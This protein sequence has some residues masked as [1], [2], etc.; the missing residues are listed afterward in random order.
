MFKKLLGWLLIVSIV[1]AQAVFPLAVKPNESLGFSLDSESIGIVNDGSEWVFFDQFTGYNTKADPSKVRD[2]DNPMGQNTVIN[3]TDRISVRDLGLATY[4]ADSTAA[5]STDG[6][7]SLHTFRKRS[8]ENILMRAYSTTTEFYDEYS[9]RWET[10]KSG[11]ATGTTFGFADFNINTDL[12]SYVYYGN[13]VN[14]FTRWTGAHTNLTSALVGGESTVPVVSTLDG[15]V[16]S[17]GSLTICGVTV[18][19]T[20]KTNTSFTGTTNVPAC[21][22]GR[23]VLQ[24][25]LEFGDSHPKGNIYLVA[26]N[27]LFISGVAST[28][29]A[30]FFSQYGDA[31]VYSATGVTA[32][33]AA[34]PG[35]FN[36][37][38]GGGGVT[39]MIQDESAIYIFK[40]SIIYKATLSDTLYTL[41]ALKPFDGKSQTT[42]AVNQNSVFTGGNGV[43][44]I[45]PDNQIMNLARVDS[46][47]YPQTIPI[48]DSIKPTAAQAVF[49]SSSGIF[50]KDRAFISAKKDSDSSVNDVVFVYNFRVG[51]WE[52]PI[53]GWNV[54]DLAIYNDELF[55]A[56]Q[57]STNVYRVTD[58]PLDDIYGVKANWRS[59][60]YTFGSP[61]WQKEVTSVFIEGYITDNTDLSISL[62]LD[63]NGFTQTYTTVFEGSETAFRFDA[64]S[65]NLFGFS[66]FGTERFGSND[67]FSGKR[68]FRVYLNKN[69]R[70]IPFYVA[71]L[72]FASDGE[73]QQWEITRFGFLV[74]RTE[75]PEKRSIFRA[76]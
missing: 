2:G 73:N 50:F 47:D 52:S 46:V 43:F 15:F 29:Q 58:I 10:I 19:Y 23:A 16:S 36:L 39:A 32:S 55:I 56:S 13:G 53:I 3:N 31:N 66:Q 37:G 71:Q 28:S 70:R 27:R 26:N 40:R 33:T 44:F 22:N 69:V 12:V 68:K 8:G 76:F 74:R 42:G 4:P 38:E 63:E 64:P 9:D 49:A 20:G 25:P 67:D 1:L 35:V 6:V 45:T 54:A 14:P 21:D 7:N 48:S 41:S 61:A 24:A 17:T 75:E 57:N 62:L 60:Q 30:V 72:E 5:T 18:G 59:K 11:Y 34:S 65:Y 51:S